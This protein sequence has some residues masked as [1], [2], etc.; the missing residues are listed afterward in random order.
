M[1][2]DIV[3]MDINKG[4]TQEKF[5]LAQPEGLD[6]AGRRTGARRRRDAARPRAKGR[7]KKK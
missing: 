3:K 5:A 6:A 2:I 4:V 7:V 1:V